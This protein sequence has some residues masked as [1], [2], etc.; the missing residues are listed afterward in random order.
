MKER[1]KYLVCPKC[2]NSFYINTIFAIDKRS[3]W[4]CPKCRH[5]FTEEE[6]EDK[7]IKISNII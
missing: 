4:L 2:K 3:T 1:I 5:T 7:N 6:G